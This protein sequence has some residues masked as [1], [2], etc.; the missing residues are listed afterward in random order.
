MAARLAG[1]IAGAQGMPV[2]ILKLDGEKVGDAAAA[3]DEGSSPEEKKER[4]SPGVLGHSEQDQ[5]QDEAQK[6]I[7]GAQSRTQSAGELKSDPVA[8]EVKAGAKKSA[9]KMIADESEPDPE[10]VHLIAR[11]PLDSPA[12]VV[13][14][15]ARK[16]YDMMLIGRADGVEE[17]GVFADKL[18]QL[19][20]GFEGPLA[21]F[22]SPRDE[23]PQLHAR[24]RLLVPVNGSSQSRRAAEIAFAIARGTGARVHVLF[25]SQTDGRSRT[26]LREERVLKDM[27]DLGERYAVPVSTRISAIT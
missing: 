17:G 13:R 9:A 7:S 21:V 1:L 10:R 15:E 11:V 25:V 2:T 26:R 19:A 24:S 20:A 5:S 14:D 16:G 27:A 4:N 23:T 8:K 3:D 18:T 6:E 22:V 12:E